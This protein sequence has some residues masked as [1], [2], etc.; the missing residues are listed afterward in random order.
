M[1]TDSKMTAPEFAQM[2]MKKDM[3]MS[4][5]LKVNLS[6]NTPTQLKK[7]RSEI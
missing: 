2:F 5:N 6:G 4:E 1:A 3:N 7:N